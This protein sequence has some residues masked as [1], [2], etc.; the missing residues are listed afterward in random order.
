[1]K[2][3]GKLPRNG[4]STLLDGAGGVVAMGRNDRDFTALLQ[5]TNSQNSKGL[6]SPGGQGDIST[7]TMPR[8]STSVSAGQS[9]QLL[10]G[11]QGL[12]EQFVK[13]VVTTVE[14]VTAQRVQSAIVS[15]LGN[16]GG[17]FPRRRGRPPKNPFFS[18]ALLAPVRPRQKQLCPVPG[19]TN[20]AAP[21]FGMVCAQH[22]DLPKAKI[23]E[24]R[25][26][27]RAAKA[28]AKAKKN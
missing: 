27:R 22:K 4:E 28:K 19:C 1:V 6:Y 10:Q 15:A 13:Q 20:A 12:I 24:Y 16:G 7:T 3:G 2:S 23:K 26:A 21:V 18:A 5:M 8:R 25:A 11:L 14:A 17:V 9:L